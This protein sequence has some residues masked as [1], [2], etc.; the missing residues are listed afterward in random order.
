[1]SYQQVVVLVLSCDEV[2]LDMGFSG[3]EHA[4]GG[5]ISASKLV[6]KGSDGYLD[7]TPYMSCILKY[8]V[9]RS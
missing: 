8:M 4:F 6:D 9:Y 5:T 2:I 1:M 3:Q 7:S